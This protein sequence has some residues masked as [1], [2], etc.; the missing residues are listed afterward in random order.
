MLGKCLCGLLLLAP[1]F[2]FGQTSALPATQTLPIL[3]RADLP[4]YP[5]IAKAAHVTGEIVI[6]VTVQSGKV[7]K[8]EIVH[9]RVKNRSQELMPESGA[10]WL[11]LPALEN[12]KSW[13]FDTDV[14]SVIVVNYTYEIAGTATDNPTNPR[15]EISPSLDVNIT[16]R[17]VKPVVEY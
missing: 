11:T 15:V 12:V 7:I 16:A 2:S 4:M 13:R 1:I 8:T 3:R 14:N 6:R 5:P 9:A 17:P 10:K